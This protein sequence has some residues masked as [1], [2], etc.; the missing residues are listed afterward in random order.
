VSWFLA[1]LGFMILIVL[2]EAGHFVAAKA[3]GMRVERFA[4]FFPPLLARK[5]IGETE[6]AIGAI[7]AGGY[8]KISGMNPSEDLPEEVRDR[9]Y[10]AQPVWKRVTVIAAGPLVNLVLGFILLVVYFAAVGP[11]D[12]DR[13]NEIGAIEKNYPA[14]DVL[15]AG[16]HVI[17]V[18]GKPG[19][20]E[21]LRKIV[22]ADRCP[23]SSPAAGCKGAEPLAVT[24][25]RD[26]RR[27]TERI[28]PIYDAERKQ[29][30]LGFSY[31]ANSGPRET[32]GFS[33]AIDRSTSAFAEISERTV[34]IPAKILDSEQRKEIHGLVGNYEVTRQTILHDPGDVVAIMAIISLALAIVNLYPFLPLDGG[35]IFWAIVEKIRG[36]PVSL[37][38]MEKSGFVGFAL[39]AMLFVIGLSNDIGVLKGEGFGPP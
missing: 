15:H 5:K 38:T 37:A 17:A 16:D 12:A 33:E 14:Q 8:V 29:M 34:T 20:P 2:H 31:D 4:L 27:V 36:K 39:V 18:N 3:V 11:H 26:G 30:R 28:T 35:H 24:V 32:L 1:A 22:Q 10:H 7:P 23:Q 21:E 9:A 6:Y 25:E 19:T 13:A